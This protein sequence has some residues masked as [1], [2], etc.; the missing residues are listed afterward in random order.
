MLISFPR[1]KYRW[2]IYMLNPE[3]PQFVSW[4]AQGYDPRQT[5]ITYVIAP[6]WARCWREASALHACIMLYPKTINQNNFL[7]GWV[8]ILTKA[9]FLFF[10]HIVSSKSTRLGGVELRS[11]VISIALSNKCVCKIS[12]YGRLRDWCQWITNY[13]LLQEPRMWV[14]S[15]EEIEPI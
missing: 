13:T 12:P 10:K 14:Y 6:V 5:V 4:R 1:S 3:E 8:F 11:P 2:Y 7:P 9:S 15:W